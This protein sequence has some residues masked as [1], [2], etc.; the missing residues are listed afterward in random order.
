MDGKM[1]I[2]QWISR[3]NYGKCPQPISDQV[4]DVC[5]RSPIR[6]SAGKENL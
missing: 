1:I 6:S 4:I 3:E 5:P 2:H